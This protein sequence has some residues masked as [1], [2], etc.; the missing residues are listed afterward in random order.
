MNKIEKLAKRL[1]QLQDLSK[2]T[3]QEISD[4]D[5]K[6]GKFKELNVDKLKRGEPT[7]E[8]IPFLMK[9]EKKIIFL[10]EIEE[11]IKAI[12]KEFIVAKLA[13]LEKKEAAEQKILKKMNQEI[14]KAEE[15]VRKLEQDYRKREYSRMILY[16]KETLEK[17]LKEL[18]P[19]E[20]KEPKPFD[21]DRLLRYPNYQ[22]LKEKRKL[23]AR[24][25]KSIGEIG[26]YTDKS[27]LKRFGFMPKSKS[28]KEIE[29]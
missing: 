3:R 20:K 29:K 15:I 21:P 13:D 23:K 7:S 4:L 10:E 8:E 11:A 2:R 25:M 27:G 24:K 17:Q 19:E 9:K 5:E 26:E 28:K 22:E 1:S 14:E 12:R 16:E 6:K 18:T